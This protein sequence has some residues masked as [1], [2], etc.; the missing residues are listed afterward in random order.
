MA[1]TEL[2]SVG[3]LAR[4]DNNDT[5]VARVMSIRIGEGNVVSYELEWDTDEK[6]SYASHVFSASRVTA[7]DLDDAGKIQIGFGGT[8]PQCGEATVICRS[9]K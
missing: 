8:H 5:F 9:N 3:S 7:F 2:L 1:T 4:F 6:G